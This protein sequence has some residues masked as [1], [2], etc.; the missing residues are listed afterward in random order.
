MCIFRS[1]NLE[2]L[3]S[4]AKLSDQLTIVG[5]TAPKGATTLFQKLTAVPVGITGKVRKESALTDI[6]DMLE[7]EIRYEI[8][9]NRFMNAW[10]KT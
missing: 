7:K 6:I 3:K 9:T 4:F 2:A 1:N 8:R 5:R 10:Q